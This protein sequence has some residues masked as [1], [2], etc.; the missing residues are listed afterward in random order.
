LYLN[1]LTY[2][3]EQFRAVVL[4]GELPDWSG[5][6]LYSVAAILI[7]WLSLVWFQKIRRGFADVL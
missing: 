3:I 7:A 2:I 6:G 1:P 4:W 5:L